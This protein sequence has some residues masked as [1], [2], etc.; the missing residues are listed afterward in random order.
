MESVTQLLHNPRVVRLDRIVDE[1]PSIRS[2]WFSDSTLHNAKPGQFAMV[3]VPG[4]DEV[5]MSVL[6]FHGKTEAGGGI[7]KGGA[8]STA[9]LG[10]K[11]GGKVWGRGPL[12]PPL[13]LGRHHQHPLFRRGTGTVSF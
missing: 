13:G 12:G 8:G 3:W 5:P 1:T 10:E 2:F 4:V 11:N 9:R 6:A 7:K